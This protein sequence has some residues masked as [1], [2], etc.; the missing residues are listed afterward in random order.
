VALADLI[1]LADQIA[2]IKATTGRDQPTVI[3]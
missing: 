1:Q 2:Q 3:T